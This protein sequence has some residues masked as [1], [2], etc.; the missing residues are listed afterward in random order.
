MML[1]SN[2]GKLP[3]PCLNSLICL[4]VLALGWH[5]LCAPPK[6][7]L[8]WEMSEQGTSPVSTAELWCSEAYWYTFS[9]HRTLPWPPTCWLTA[10]GDGDEVSSCK[11]SADRKPARKH[12]YGNSEF[13]TLLL[14]PFLTR[15][16]SAVI[17][18]AGHFATGRGS[19]MV[20]LWRGIVSI[21]GKINGCR[22]M[23]PESTSSPNSF[24][25]CCLFI[26]FSQGLVK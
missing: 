10:C 20:F 15:L 12:I 6:H 1:R 3:A 22:I 13:A 14:C 23:N 18:S 7:Y 25:S 11:A 26:C 2:A 16:C 17:E 8:T 5:S 4:L 19:S 24:F 21:H 9:M